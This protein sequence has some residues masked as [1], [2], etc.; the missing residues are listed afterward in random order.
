MKKD[1]KPPHVPAKDL[2]SSEELSQ[3]TRLALFVISLL[4]F[5]VEVAEVTEGEKSILE[6][7]DID[8]PFTD[9]DGRCSWN[10]DMMMKLSEELHIPE[11]FIEIYSDL[12]PTEFNPEKTDLHS[13]YLK[14]L[15]DPPPLPLAPSSSTMERPV[16]ASLCNIIT[17]SKLAIFLIAN[18]CYDARGRA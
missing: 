5:S 3:Q 14:L 1:V 6:A 2:F 7:Q 15:A 10:M 17:I 4:N 12:L 8:H 18:G 16:S 13:G 9:V 11:Q